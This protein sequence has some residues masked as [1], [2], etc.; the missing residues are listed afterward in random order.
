MSMRGP[1][2]EQC[3]PSCFVSIDASAQ[4]RCSSYFYDL[5]AGVEIILLLSLFPSQLPQGLVPRSSESWRPLVRWLA[6]GSHHPI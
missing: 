1:A 6:Q 3:W 5:E 2:N 4:V